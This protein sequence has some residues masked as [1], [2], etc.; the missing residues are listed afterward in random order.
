MG[1]SKFPI[2]DVIHYG[3]YYNNHKEPKFMYQPTAGYTHM[4][5]T[6][7]WWMRPNDI[8]ALETAC[9][10]WYGFKLHLGDEDGGTEMMPEVIGTQYQV[11]KSGEAWSTSTQGDTALVNDVLVWLDITDPI[12]AL[13]TL[14]TRSDIPCAIRCDVHRYTEDEDYKNAFDIATEYFI[15]YFITGSPKKLAGVSYSSDDILREIYG[16]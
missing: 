8:P 13:G 16:V 1:R 12:Q 5:S 9:E 4:A 3:V 14:K 6:Q 2:G 15:E 10:M 7:L 11:R